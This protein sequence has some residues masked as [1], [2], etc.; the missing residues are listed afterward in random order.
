MRGSLG[1]H[2]LHGPERAGS[3]RTGELAHEIAINHLENVVK[4][5]ES[6]DTPWVGAEQFRQ[7]FHLTDLKYDD[8][9]TLWENYARM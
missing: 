7:F 8:K 1:S 3:D 5:F 4:V 6:E 2:Q 9:H